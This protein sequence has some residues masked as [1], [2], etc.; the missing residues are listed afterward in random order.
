[1]RRIRSLRVERSYALLAAE[2]V[3]DLPVEASY[4]MARDDNNIEDLYRVAVRKLPEGVAQNYWDSVFRAQGDDDWD[5][6]EAKAVT[7]VLALHPD[8][9]EA[10]ERAAEQLVRTWLREHQRSISSLPDARKVAYEAAKRETRDPQLTDLVLP[11][12]QVVREPCRRWPRHLLAAEDGTYPSELKGWEERVLEAE[13]ADDDLAGWYRNP[14]GG[15]GSVHVPYQGSQHE[16]AMYSDFLLFHRTDQGIR[17][18]LIDPHGYHLADAAAKLRGPATY[19]ARHSDAFLRI[20]AVVET[21]ERRLLALDLKS[22]AVREAI[23]DLRD[24]DVLTLFA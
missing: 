5:P 22:A 3:D 14:T 15:A 11:E 12:T 1:L 9:V 23:A 17:P 20:H 8:V 7:A 4:D 16:R 10:V 2:S 18:S 24:E 13:L 19:A 21:P 6:V